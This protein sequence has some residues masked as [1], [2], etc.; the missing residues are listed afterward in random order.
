MAEPD[1]PGPPPAPKTTID[2]DGTY[3]VGTDIVPGTYTSAG[4]AGDIACFW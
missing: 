2:N 3:V 4:P 1:V